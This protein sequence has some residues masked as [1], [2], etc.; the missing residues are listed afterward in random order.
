MEIASTEINKEMTEDDIIKIFHKEFRTFFMKQYEGAK[1]INNICWYEYD[2]NKTKTI[3]DVFNF[4][5]KSVYD[6]EEKFNRS[7]IPVGNYHIIISEVISKYEDIRERKLLD[8]LI[9]LY[10][11]CYKNIDIETNKNIDEETYKNQIKDYKNDINKIN[12]LN[13][14]YI[15]EQR[16][17]IIENCYEE[18]NKIENENVVKNKIIFLI[19][20][21]KNKFNNELNQPFY[22][23]NLSICIHNNT[24]HRMGAAASTSGADL[25]TIQELFNCIINLYD[26]I[27][28]FFS[29]DKNKKELERINQKKNNV[30]TL[31]NIF[32]NFLESYK[33]II[34]MKN[35]ILTKEFSDK[36]MDESTILEC[37]KLKG[38]LLL[39]I[40]NLDIS[41]KLEPVV[42]DESLKLKENMIKLETNLHNSV[43]IMMKS[44]ILTKES[45]DKIMN[46]SEELKYDRLKETFVFLIKNDNTINTDIAS[47]AEEEKKIMDLETNLRNNIIK[48][49]ELQENMTELGINLDNYIENEI[50]KDKN[51]EKPIVNI[52][53]PI[54]NIEKPIDNVNKKE[55]TYNV[56]KKESVHKVNIK[57]GA[58]SFDT[59]ILAVIS[60]II[61]IIVGIVVYSL[62]K[63]NDNNNL[64]N[65]NENKINIKI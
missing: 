25:D 60:I 47:K 45:L 15:I 55:S 57:N 27:I 14:K 39:F 11:Y 32:A 1:Y 18:C 36:I 52:K 34:E 13:F 51:I 62:K 49:F 4:L 43:I 7:F 28:V 65:I 41:K 20:L 2:K 44:R 3:I 24:I 9:I 35:Q 37:K 38:K 5:Y 50:I 64:K 42:F 16:K 61:I 29:E 59:K 33:K 10:C 6:T 63:Y 48:S 23:L 19:E 8:N 54:V 46:E 58:T 21:L 53:K 30:K 56:N 31:Q 26:E 17:K 40:K 12:D 22:L